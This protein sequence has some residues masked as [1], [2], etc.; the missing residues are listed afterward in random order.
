DDSHLVAAALLGSDQ[1]PALVA[2]RLG[3]GLDLANDG[4]LERRRA[5]EDLAELRALGAQVLQ[6]LLDLDR[7]EARELTQA[8]VEDVVG[9][10]VAQPE[11]LDQRQIRLLG[12]ADDRDHLVDVEQHELPAFEDVDALLDLAQSMARA[13]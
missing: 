13:P 7:L 1:R 3:V 2:I 5:G 12:G 11:A 9:L 6:L 4:A 10:P 8:N